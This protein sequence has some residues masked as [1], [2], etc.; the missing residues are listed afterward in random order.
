[1]TGLN[2]KTTNANS[3]V[4]RTPDL[5]DFLNKQACTMQPAQ[6]LDNSCRKV[7]AVTPPATE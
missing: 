4:E 3:T 1:V 6:A 7:L 5:N 2:R